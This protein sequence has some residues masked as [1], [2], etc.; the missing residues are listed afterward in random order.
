MNMQASIYPAA[1]KPAQLTVTM[2]AIRA[3]GELSND[4]NPIHV[5]PEF[6]ATTPMGGVIAHGTLSLCLLWQAVQHSFCAEVFND[7]DL[8][9]RFVKPVRVGDVLTAGGE[10][11]PDGSYAVWV[12]GPAGDDRIVGQI[13]LNDE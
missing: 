3:Y 4:F 13:Q 10:R 5:D 2:D 11:Q 9:V 6:A 1:L 12:R 8:D 7:L